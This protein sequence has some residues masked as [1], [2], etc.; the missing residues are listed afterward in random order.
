MIFG[1]HN[2]KHVRRLF[3]WIQFFLPAPAP[4]IGNGI[5]ST[6]WVLLDQLDQKD[7]SSFHYARALVCFLL[8]NHRK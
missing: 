5:L 2:S 1:L 3:K 8:F 7:L 6:D 4:L